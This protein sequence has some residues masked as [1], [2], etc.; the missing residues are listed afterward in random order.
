[1]EKAAKK[2]RLKIGCLAVFVLGLA[3]GWWF[4]GDL[5]RHF[6]PTIVDSVRP[7]EKQTYEGDSTAN[8]R[9]MHTALLGYEESEGQFPYASGWMTAIENRLGTD[10]LKKGEGEKKMIHPEFVGQPGKYGY[11]YNKSL[12]GKYR[13]DLKDPKTILIFESSTTDKNASGDPSQ[14]RKKGGLAIT[15]D[16]QILRD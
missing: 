8:L 14:V 2:K 16:G 13:G 5:I 9:A 11:A 4:Y 6:W 1:M 3:F 12:E 15:L 7:A 10:V